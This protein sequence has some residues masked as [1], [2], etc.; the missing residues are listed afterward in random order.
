MAEIPRAVREEAERAFAGEELELVLAELG[1]YGDEV[2]HREPERVL[3]GV[4]WLAEGDADA[5]VRH[6]EI[7]KRDYR[8][9]LAV[10]PSSRPGPTGG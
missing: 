9:V 8:D 5:V 6:L 10:A 4:L 1:S 3:L 7:A 2:W